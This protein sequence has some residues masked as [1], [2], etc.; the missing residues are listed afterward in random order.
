MMLQTILHAVNINQAVSSLLLH[1]LLQGTFIDTHAAVA[2]REIR[3]YQRSDGILLP[4]T[5]FAR[6]CREIMQE[7]RADFR[8]QKSAIG[9][10]GEAAEAFLVNNLEGM[11]EKTL[12]Y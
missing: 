12:V 6:L 9:A 1:L 8:M 7:L 5:P 2:L 10:L 11:I 4:Y 3:H